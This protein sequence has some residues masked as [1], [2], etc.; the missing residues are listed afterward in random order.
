[1]KQA[2]Y[3]PRCEEPD[4]GRVQE[5]RERAGEVTVQSSGRQQN[6][7][8]EPGKYTLTLAFPSPSTQWTWVWVDSSS[9]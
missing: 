8:G 9:W 6:R 4:R 7:R 3:R 1:M 2:L 5:S